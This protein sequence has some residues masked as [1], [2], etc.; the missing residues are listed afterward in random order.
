MAVHIVFQKVKGFREMFFCTS[1]GSIVI[2]VLHVI[3]EHVNNFVREHVTANER[4]LLKVDDSKSRN[5]WKW[6]SVCREKK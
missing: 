2:N 4:Y 1:N 5:G 3:I 6:L